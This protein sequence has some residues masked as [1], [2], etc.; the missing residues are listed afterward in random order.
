MEMEVKGAFYRLLVEKFNVNLH[1]STQVFSAVL[2]A[3]EESRIFGFERPE[4]C[5]F[6]ESTIYDDN[7]VPV[8]VLHSHYR[9]D[10]Y[11]FKAQSGEYLFRMGDDE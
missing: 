4:P 5:I 11:R 7:D 3:E 9:A 10:R 8:E 6:L 2:A 1:H